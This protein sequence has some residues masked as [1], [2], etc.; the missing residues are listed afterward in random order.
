[1]LISPILLTATP[2]SSWYAHFT[3]EKLRLKTRIICSRAPSLCA[4]K[5]SVSSAGEGELLLLIVWCCYSVELEDFRNLL[6]S[7]IS[8]LAKDKLSFLTG[9]CLLVSFVKVWLWSRVLLLVVWFLN[10]AGVVS[11]LHLVF[12]V[13]VVFP[14]WCFNVRKMSQGIKHVKIKCVPPSLSVFFFQAVLH[15][16]L[17]HLQCK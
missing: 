10:Q 5:T 13:N 16:L 7:T 9:F 4:A 2:W 3:D 14:G 12:H 17:L 15:F 11:T 1:M 6:A 8:D